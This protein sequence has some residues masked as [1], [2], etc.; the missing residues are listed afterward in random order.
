MDRRDGDIAWTRPNRHRLPFE[1]IEWRKYLVGKIKPREAHPVCAIDTETYH[2]EAKLI[3]DSF[4][5]TLLDGDID[6]I[7]SFLTHNRFRQSYI[8]AFNLQYDAEAILKMLPEEN[9]Q[10]IV[11]T[12]KTT[13]SIYDLKYIPKKLLTIKDQH[14]NTSRLFDIAQFYEMSLD[15]ALKKYLGEEKYEYPHRTLLNTS[16][17][18]WREETPEII[19]YCKKDAFQTGKLAEFLQGNIQ[20]LFSFNPRQYISKASLAKDLVR[21][22]GYMPDVRKIPKGA[23]KYAFYAYKG[24]RFEVCQR[25]YFPT[26]ELYDINSAYSMIIR[27]LID[28]TYGEWRRVREVN[29]NAYY[30]FYLCSVFVLPSFLCPMAYFLPNGILSFPAG[31]FKTYLTKEE[32]IAYEQY[33]AIDVLHGWEFYPSRIR[34]PFRRYIDGLFEQKQQY[35]KSDYQYDLVKKM[36]NSLYGCFYEKHIEDGRIRAGLLF[37]PV[38]ATLTTALT[39]VKL[40]KAAK[41]FET[42]VIA[43]QTDSV[44]FDRP[45][46]LTTSKTLGG[47]QLESAGSAVILQSGIYEVAGKLRI[48]GMSH[49]KNIT[50]DGKH[51]KNVFNMIRKNP[52][53]TIYKTTQK[54]PLHLRECMQRTKTLTKDDIN[55]WSAEKKTTDVNA[56][57]KRRWSEVFEHGGDI[58]TTSHRSQPW[59]LYA[60]K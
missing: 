47:W 45:I 5:N 51:Y 16:A 32:I 44:L 3:A 30:G 12:N 41:M 35:Q 36:M 27:N 29:E 49:G 38:Y 56:D 8:F 22:I 46:N 60:D 34:Y 48:R 10:D 1:A 37:N 55:V 9:I 23:L 19:H 21:I 17:K 4:G 15:D 25:G 58:F 11:D 40:F 28:V 33:A 2:G 57:I 39:R 26:T 20:M 7:L 53:P 59:H 6:G 50:Y 42:S 31:R 54:R 18:I 43:M 13:Y 24:G 14:R 52:D